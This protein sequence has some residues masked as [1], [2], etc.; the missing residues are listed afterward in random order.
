[1]A[2]PMVVTNRS[3][4]RRTT[5]R[6]RPL[7]LVC[8]TSTFRLCV[9]KVWVF[10]PYLQGEGCDLSG[11]LRIYNNFGDCDSLLVMRISICAHIIFCDFTQLSF[12][13]LMLMTYINNNLPVSDDTDIN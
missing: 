4:R 6:F 11:I 1:M 3:V 5:R 13:L 9:R 10:C 8:G 12:S 7:N 2:Q